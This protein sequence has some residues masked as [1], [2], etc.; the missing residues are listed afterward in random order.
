MDMVYEMHSDGEKGLPK[1]GPGVLGPSAATLGPNP[2]CALLPRRAG[3]APPSLAPVSS[4][5]A[6]FFWFPLVLC[7]LASAL[8]SAATLDSNSEYPP[9]ACANVVDQLQG[10]NVLV[11]INGSL[12]TF[13]VP[14][15]EG[16]PFN[17]KPVQYLEVPDLREQNRTTLTCNRNSDP[18]VLSFD[19][20]GC[21]CVLKD[22]SLVANGVN[23][24]ARTITVSQCPA[25]FAETVTTM[26]IS[27][28][29]I[30]TEEYYDNTLPYSSASNFSYTNPYVPHQTKAQKRVHGPSPR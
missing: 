19:F 18:T 17:E 9:Q 25:P 24:T 5:M 30:T 28:T 2:F 12:F 16:G 3:V 29:N 1:R 8:V 14:S 13:H 21:S 15:V 27:V 6:R 10:S 23:K 22:T 20:N 26:L 7:L 4:T 11:K